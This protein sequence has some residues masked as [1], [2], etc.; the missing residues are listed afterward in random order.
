MGTLATSI[1][2]TTSVTNQLLGTLSLF[3][4][5]ATVLVAG[6][7]LDYALFLSRPEGNS[8]NFQDTRHAVLACAFS[9][10]AAFL[11]LAFSAVPVLRSIGTTVTIGVLISFL[12]ARTG[13]QIATH[14][15]DN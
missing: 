1:I 15:P 4:L 6:L 3:N 8:K 11:V 13:I 10:L 5:I 12:L 7:G 9:T 2:L 14:S